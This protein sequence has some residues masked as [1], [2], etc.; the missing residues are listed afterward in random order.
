MHPYPHTY[1]A[2]AS[3][4][5]KGSVTVGSPQLPSFETAAPPEFDGP[6]GVW[7]PETLLCAS[8]ADCFILTFRA[9]SRA[10]R[11]EWSRLECRVEGVL[12]RVGRT[13]QF[14]RYTT[15]AKLS[16]PD[17]A[18]TAKARELLERAEQGCLIANSVNGSRALET[19]ISVEGAPTAAAA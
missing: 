9:V 8:L 10:A 11:F 2:S 12:E 14:T 5:G 6:G 4:R 13:S 19:Q 16:V 18:D 17:G 15:F 7:S 1:I 3:A